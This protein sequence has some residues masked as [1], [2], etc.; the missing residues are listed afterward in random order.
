LPQRKPVQKSRRA[1]DDDEPRDIDPLGVA[2]LFA[3][4]AALL[5]ATVSWL[6]SAVVPLS[7]GASV[8]GVVSLVRAF[9]RGHA[10]ML[11]PV[12]GAVVPTIVL[13]VAWLFPG[14]LGPTYSDSRDTE[15]VDPQLIRRIP[16]PG[17]KDDGAPEDPDWANA[18]RVALRQGPVTVQVVEVAL[19]DFEG[20]ADRPGKTDS[21]LVVH[22]LVQRMPDPGE[23]AGT[24]LTPGAFKSQHTPRLRDVAG[25]AW[26]LREVRPGHIGEDNQPK[27]AVGEMVTTW[28]LIFES[29]AS[30]QDL[31]LEI[32][33]SAWGGTGTFRFAIPGQMIKR[34]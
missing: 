10:R 20:P 22:L 26:K 7:L 3:G 12:A 34:S 2:A 23:V 19:G 24:A 9:R 27:F 5:C 31:R 25:K 13:L 29:A 17:V 11:F 8:L 15:V 21:G 32:P 18:A 28:S 33:A 16:L 6:C 14:L 4:C 1:D 30:A